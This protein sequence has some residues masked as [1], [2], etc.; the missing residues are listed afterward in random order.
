MTAERYLVDIYISKLTNYA[1]TIISYNKSA[2]H[3]G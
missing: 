1:L 2:Y 3:A